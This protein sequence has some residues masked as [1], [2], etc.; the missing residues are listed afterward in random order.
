MARIERALEKALGRR[1]FR[2]GNPRLRSIPYPDV[3][4]AYGILAIVVLVSLCIFIAQPVEPFGYWRDLGF[5]HETAAGVVFT[6]HSWTDAFDALSWTPWYNSPLF[7]LNSNVSEAVIVAVTWISGNAWLAVKIVQVLEVILAGCAAFAMYSAYS[8][9]RFWGMVFGFS[10]A[11]LPAVTLA[12]RGNPAIGWIAVLAPAAIAGGTFLIRAYGARALPLVGFM[13]GAAGYGIGLEYA[14]FSSAPLFALIVAGE[15]RSIPLQG[16]LI[17]APLGLACCAAM[18]AFFMLPTFLGPLFSDSAA[19]TDSLVTGAFLGNFSESWTGFLTFVPREAYVSPFPDYNATPDMPGL[20]LFG[21]IVWAGALGNLIRPR[22]RSSGW[23]DYASISVVAACVILAMGTL[24]PL[25]RN[26]WDALFLIPHLDAIRTTDRFLLVPSVMIPF[27]YVCSLERVARRLPLARQRVAGWV[28]LAVI[29]SF[30][31]FGS[32]QHCFAVEASKGM[33]QPEIDAVQRVVVAEGG[34]TASF[35]GVNEGFSFE[36]ASEYGVPEPVAPAAGDLGWRFL[37]D[38]H[39]AVGLLGRMGVHT[40]VSAPNWTG[41]VGFPNTANV[42][43]RLAS[44]PLIFKSPENVFVSRLASRPDVS[45]QTGLCIFGGPGGFDL[46]ATAAPVQSTAFLE[47]SDHCRQTGFVNF[48]A[49]DRW[50][51]PTTLEAWAASDLLPTGQRIRDIDYPFV[52]NRVLLNVPWYRNSVDGD[53]TVFSSSGAV[54]VA[55]PIDIV[56]PSTREWPSGTSI[57]IRLCSHVTGSLAILDSRNN[58]LANIPVLAANGFRWYEARTIRPKGAAEVVSLHL[59]PG[60]QVSDSGLNGF[61]FDG[62][63]ISEPVQITPPDARPEF[64]AISLDRFAHASESFGPNV[65]LAP[66]SSD[67]ARPILTGMHADNIDG[68]PVWRADGAISQ[69]RF[70]WTGANGEYEIRVRA[71]LTKYGETAGLDANSRGTCCRVTAA[72]E[73]GFSGLEG[74]F[75]LNKGSQIVVRLVSPD[76][77]FQDSSRI[78]GVDLRPVRFLELPLNSRNGGSGIIDFSQPLEALSQISVVRKLRIDPPLARGV[79][80][81]E[82]SATS[83]LN[84]HP[85]SV[86]VEVL[87]T[88]AGDA[89]ATLTCGGGSTHEAPLLDDDTTL[90]VSGRD[91]SRCSIGIHWASAN[92]GIRYIKV[93]AGGVT[94]P[95]GTAMLWLPAGRYRVSILKADGSAVRRVRLQAA[96]CTGQEPIC[97]FGFTGKHRI[98]LGETSPAERLLTFVRLQPLA[99]PPPI[100]VKQTAALRWDVT[101]KKT[102]DVVLTQIYDGNWILFDGFHQYGGERCDIADTCFINVPSGRYH[103]GHRWPLPLRQGFAITLTALA[104]G[105]AFVLLSFGRRRAAV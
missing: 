55:S 89:A 30:V 9:S 24:I 65:V 60:S 39:G 33:R 10:Y 44:A 22:A 66:D 36:D 32:S 57:A 70:R 48:D 43:R 59:Q 80:G 26:L 46:L 16:W 64:V 103:L 79:A 7:Y 51:Q 74:R 88:G 23:T 82:L 81:S 17:F 56:L 49:R 52:P 6:V 40:V 11:A 85:K 5:A 101:L 73:P 2:Y 93:T 31:W 104:I 62:V 105:L 3:V 19:R 4:A 95:E 27:W 12:I 41:A 86:T 84:G 67:A 91:V 18:G 21:A 98:V 58:P 102:A 75:R 77:E 14:V 96:G 87:K 54:E 99:P 35:A 90:A 100:E 92:L 25:G 13:C 1:L 76:F 38:G 37:E 28:S 71:I 97:T 45:S 94:T 34:K 83:I 47:P 42:F 8:T 78:V 68:T 69:V 61:A 72:N 53:R 15:R 29:A 50:M 63:A 20:F